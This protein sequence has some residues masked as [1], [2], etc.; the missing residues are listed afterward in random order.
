MP[1]GFLRSLL[2]KS[3][4]QKSTVSQSILTSPVSIKSETF[5]QIATIT[6]VSSVKDIPLSKD[7]LLVDDFEHG[8]ASLYESDNDNGKISF[9]ILK[10]AGLKG[11]GLKVHYILE[12][13]EDYR[14]TDIARKFSR[15]EGL[16]DWSQYTHL[17]FVIKVQAPSS[18]LR[19]CIVEADE[20]WWNFINQEFLEGGKWYWIRIP[21]K[22]MFI[23]K[24]FSVQGDGKQDL[25]RV[26]ELRFIFDSIVLGHNLTEN[27]VYLDQIF[28]SK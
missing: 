22:K 6:K 21:L 17:N 19:T 3:P 25:S 15:K 20:D 28:L 14:S 16:Q 18:V 10:G 27:T 13:I 24:N 9:E 4:Q 5:P 2:K 11:K 26:A 23:L 8:D 12:P 7:T 1:L